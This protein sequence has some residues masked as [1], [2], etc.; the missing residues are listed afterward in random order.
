MKR[1]WDLV[2]GAAILVG[3][4]ALRW[5]DPLP[6]QQLRA[7]TFD[8]Y[9]RL[10]P[11]AYDPASPVTIAAI[12]EKSLAVFGQWPWSRITLARIADRLT[13]LGAAAV[14]FDV[15]FAEPDRTSPAA[16][17]VSLP[18]DPRYDPVRTE[19]ATL[20]DPDA[21]FAETLRRTPSIIAFTYSNDSALRGRT[22]D[23]KFGI[24]EI[25]DPELKAATF[26]QGGDFPIAPLPALFAAAHGLGDVQVGLPDPDGIVRRVPLVTRI[27]DTVFPS[28]AADSLRVALGGQTAQIRLSNKKTVSLFGIGYEFWLQGID[29]MRIGQAI[30]PVNANGELL[31]YD[32]GPRLERYISAADVLVPDFD[33]AKVQGRIVLIGAT[34]EGLKDIHATPL[35]P[36]VP[37]VEIHAQILEQI[38]AGAYLDRPYYADMLEI[39]ALAIFGLV[40]LGLLYR[41]SATGGAIVLVVAVAGSIAASWWQFAAEGFLFDPIYPA[42]AATAMFGSGTLW[43]YLRTER[44]KKFVR[45]AFAQYLSP[46]LVDRLSQHPEQLKLGGELRELTVMFSDIRDFTKISESL[47]PQ[48]LTQLMNAFLTPMTSIIQNRA[49]T[50]DKYIGDCIMAFWNAPLDVPHHAEQAILAAFD[51]RASLRRLNQSRAA[52]A[53][54]DDPAIF[55]RIGIGL[56]SG[57]G[58][59]GN[60]GSDQRF[61]YTVFGDTV[62]I[63]SRLE[64][65]SPAYHVDLVIGEETASGA[66]SLALLELDRVRVKGK[67]LPIR[68][69]T[70]LGDAGF[71]GREDFRQLEAAQERLLE[72]YRDQ[73]WDAAEAALAECRRLAAALPTDLPGALPD[74]KL[75][76]FYDLYAARIAAY[77]AAPPPA[78]W[79]GVY[80]AKS[81]AG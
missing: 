58:S 16:V 72:S 42:L 62:N 12:D 76:G 24:T 61:N 68:I 38:V 14:A 47:E 30:I 41:R 9:Q 73:E 52:A 55:I 56:N 69:F 37:G 57:S 45:H 25:G 67:V 34:V 65:L 1:G 77:R 36:Y 64:A 66:P 29:K 7:L 32:S 18:A 20:P 17:A 19:L 49:G 28:L 15:L 27:G 35:S 3:A 80:E 39:V 31:L 51:M 13:E 59:V 6:L 5:I 63:A 11:R 46:I 8:S 70:G 43:N 44:E 71:A 40:L 60:M 81:K 10:Q 75:Q 79:D 50:I 23:A 26:V 4:V 54:A 2:L 53:T 74:D 21:E 48:E 22:L 33:P 78:D